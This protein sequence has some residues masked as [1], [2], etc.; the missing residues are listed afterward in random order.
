METQDLK[1]Y[2]NGVFEYILCDGTTG[3]KLANYPLL[4]GKIDTYTNDTGERVF[5]APNAIDRT[6]RQISPTEA[7]LMLQEED[8]KAHGH[9]MT[10]DHDMNHQ[11]SYNESYND[12][13]NAH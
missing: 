12:G 6:L 9:D 11:H 1:T 7:L 3:Y 5:N 10:H 8:I 4:E 13:A 2:N